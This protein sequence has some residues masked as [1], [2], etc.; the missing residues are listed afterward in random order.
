MECG[1]NSKLQSH[2]LAFKTQK[3]QQDLD[4]AT[5]IFGKM[6]ESRNQCFEQQQ[7]HG[8]VVANFALPLDSYDLCLPFSI[9][10]PLFMVLRPLGYRCCLPLAPFDAWPIG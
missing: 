8:R 7:Q 3:V 10:E 1:L 9:E 4:K 2:Y 6:E 5:L